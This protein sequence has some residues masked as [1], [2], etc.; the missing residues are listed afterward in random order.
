M[1]IDKAALF[2]FKQRAQEL[3]K[4][5]KRKKTEERQMELKQIE[6]ILKDIGEKINDKLHKSKK[7]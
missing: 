1:V 4:T 2:T 6:Q 7:S 3:M 5:L